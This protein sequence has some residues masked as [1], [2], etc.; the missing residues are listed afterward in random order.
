[1]AESADAAKLRR[2][3]MLVAEALEIPAAIESPE[4]EH[5]LVNALLRI[6]DA[7]R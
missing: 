1:M 6:Q 2:V 4:R 7:A 5:Y 3:R